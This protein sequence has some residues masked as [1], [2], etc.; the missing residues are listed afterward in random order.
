MPFGNLAPL[1]NFEQSR[2]G[3]EQ[4]RV[5]AF[6]ELLQTESMSPSG[7]FLKKKPPCTPFIRTT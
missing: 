4:N 5:I 6:S 1:V 7:F 3:F 2:I